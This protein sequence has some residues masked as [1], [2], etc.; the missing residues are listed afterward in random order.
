MGKLPQ[1]V[2]YYLQMLIV[3]K[4]A[5][6][7]LTNKRLPVEDIVIEDDV[8]DHRMPILKPYIEISSSKK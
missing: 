7:G 2:W 4:G 6:G 5:C 1:C 3:M 8:C